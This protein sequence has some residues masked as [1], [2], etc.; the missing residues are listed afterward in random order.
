MKKAL[1]DV[2]ERG[3]SEGQAAK[4]NNVPRKTL[5]DRLHRMVKGRDECTM[6]KPTILSSA[7]EKNLCGYIAYMAQCRFPLTVNQIM[8]FA[9]CIDRNSGKSAFGDNGPCYGWWIRFK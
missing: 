9:L 4:D 6:R 3:L 8:T 5:S 7:Q 2:R 1:S